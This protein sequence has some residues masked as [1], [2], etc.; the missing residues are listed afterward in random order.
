MI[1][2]AA[3]PLEEAAPNAPGSTPDIDVGTM[4]SADSSVEITDHQVAGVLEADIIKRDEQDMNREIAPLK[5]A[6]DSVVINTTGYT[7]KESIN[8]IIET[9]KEKM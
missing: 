6:E 1:Y 8:K 9:V 3:P 4:G 5:P 2:G 7:L